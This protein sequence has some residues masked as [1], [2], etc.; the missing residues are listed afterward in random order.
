MIMPL[1]AA[2]LL[3]LLTP[4][5]FA[6]APPVIRLDIHGDP[7][8]A[9]AVARFGSMRFR[10]L[11][12]A[13]NGIAISHDGKR[14]ASLSRDLCIWDA[15]TGRLLAHFDPPKAY[16]WSVAF[17]PDGEHVVTGHSGKGD[18]VMVWNIRTGTSRTLWGD[19]RYRGTPQRFAFSRDGKTLAVLAEN[20]RGDDPTTAFIF[21][22]PSCKARTSIKLRFPYIMEGLAFDPK[23]DLLVPSVGVHVMDVKTGK[24]I[25]N[26][27]GDIGIYSFALSPDGKTAAVQTREKDKDKKVEAWVRLIRLDTGATVKTDVGGP[28]RSRMAFSPDG[29][30]LYF[31]SRDGDLVAIDPTTGKQTRTVVKSDG[32]WRPWVS[33]SGDGSRL[34]RTDGQTIRVHDMKTGKLTAS[35]D[36]HRDGSGASAIASA[37]IGIDASI[38]PDG[39]TVATRSGSEVRLW[40]LATGRYLRRIPGEKLWA[41]VRWTADGKQIAVGRPGKFS[42]YDARTTKLVREVS[43]PP[44]KDRPSSAWLLPDGKRIAIR[45]GPHFIHAPHLLVSAKD[46]KKLAYHGKGEGEELLD[47]SDDGNRLAWA[48]RSKDKVLVVRM[49]KT[50]GRRRVFEQAFTDT[51]LD[52]RLLNGG[53][54]LAISG[55]RAQEAWDVARGRR[56]GPPNAR[57]GEFYGP[58]VLT[59]SADG[60]LLVMGQNDIPPPAWRKGWGHSPSNRSR[61]FLIETATGKVRAESQIV[62]NISGA[63]FTPDGKHLLTTSADGTALLWRLDE[64]AISPRGP[65]W[66]ALA[67]ADGGRAFGAVVELSRNPKEGLALL[68]KHLKPARVDAKKLRGWLDGLDAEGFDE[69]ETAEKELRALGG[70]VEEG[71]LAELKKGPAAEP[72]VRIQ[73]LLAKAEGGTPEC[74]RHSRA[75]EALE[76][77]AT[78]E[79][80]KFLRELAAGHP[81]A[82]RTREAKE[83]LACLAV[84]K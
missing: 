7:L 15:S 52:A 19:G 32:I 36:D 5:S 17:A 21:D 4:M 47:L 54:M 72:L 38:S 55:L 14:V 79:A 20:L 10:H 77:M 34:V 51:Y 70:D 3:A 27:G 37:G 18:E 62:R 81:G 45:E 35:F 23:G 75:I 33:F 74:W 48:D 80:T 24:E 83:A 82:R 30:E 53:R 25:A 64:W 57:V 71:L 31:S 56:M 50:E 46:G 58:R 6:A 43:L 63:T 11:F 39:K 84:K 69:R 40:E 67:S 26:K 76:R 60:R 9:G 1:R 61:V 28:F 49:E 2:F 73:R 12:T 59:A 29:K 8:P 16:C 65:L 41:G 78:P 66:E 44:V 22:F 42:W 68:R 13:T